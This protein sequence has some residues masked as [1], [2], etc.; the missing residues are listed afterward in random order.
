MNKGINLLPNKKE[1][2]DKQK[3]ILKMLRTISIIVLS[4]FF[5]SSVSLFFINQKFSSENIK[6]K[7]NEVLANYSSVNLRMA[8]LFLIHDRLSEIDKILSKRVPFELKTVEIK[9]Q[10]PQDVAIDSL[11][12]SERQV[13]MTTTSVSLSSINLMLDNFTKMASDKNLIKNVLLLGVGFDGKEKYFL[14]LKMQLL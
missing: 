4:L 3:R 9:K 2:L 1:G 5:V 7:E 8:K 13:E 14:S 6:Q 11:K 12:I 10:I